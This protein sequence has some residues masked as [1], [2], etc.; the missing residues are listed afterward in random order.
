MK[1]IFI[2]GLIMQIFVPC[3]IFALPLKEMDF[4]DGLPWSHDLSLLI[5]VW[6]HFAQY[7]LHHFLTIVLYPYLSEFIWE[8]SSRIENYKIQ[9]CTWIVF[10]GHYFLQFILRLPPFS[11]IKSGLQENFLDPPVRRTVGS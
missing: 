3:W 2:W 10:L 7:V 4:R 9:R 8:K 5:I 1:D 11:V 6:G